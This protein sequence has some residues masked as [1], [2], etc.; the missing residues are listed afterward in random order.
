MRLRARGLE[1]ELLRQLQRLGAELDRPFQLFGHHQDPR[2]LLED[3][4]LRGRR[5]AFGDEL[6]ATFKMVASPLAIAPVQPNAA[7]PR[8]CLGGGLDF[9]CTKEAFRR[10]REHGVVESDVVDA[11]PRIGEQ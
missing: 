10:V 11:T 8:L 1:P 6:P 4:R 9:P 2:E 7:E 3:E 5:S